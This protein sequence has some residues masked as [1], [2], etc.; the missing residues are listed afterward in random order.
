MQCA[1]VKVLCTLYLKTP[2]LR[3]IGKKGVLQGETTY[4][5]PDNSTLQGLWKDGVLV[6]AKFTSIFVP[7]FNTGILYTHDESTTER[8]AYYPLRRDPY[9]AQYSYAKASTIP[10]AQEGLFALREICV[11]TIVALY[12]GIRVELKVADKWPWRLKPNLICL[13]DGEENDGWC[14]DVPAEYSSLSV[15]CNTIGHKANHHYSPNAEYHM[16][17]NHPILGKIRCIRA[18]K[19]IK[20]DEEIT[21]D[22]GYERGTGPD[23]YEKFM[24]DHWK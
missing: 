18:I 10:N 7:E 4:F 12:N 20:K 23:W 5:Y 14:V 24:C 13:N 8:I 11:G 3:G 1:M 15:F 22:Y 17:S 19:D 6:E 2:E 21:V 16:Y 9:E